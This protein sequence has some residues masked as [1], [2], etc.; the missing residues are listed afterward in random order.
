MENHEVE[1]K[2][3][4]VVIEVKNTWAFIVTMHYWFLRGMSVTKR[5]DMFKNLLNY[6]LDDMKREGNYFSYH[7]FSYTTMGWNGIHLKLTLRWNAAKSQTITDI[8]LLEKEVDPVATLMAM[9]EDITQEYLKLNG[10]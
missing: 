10:L 1:R 5:A 3:E 4:V 2:L 8:E 9:P 6:L 7:A